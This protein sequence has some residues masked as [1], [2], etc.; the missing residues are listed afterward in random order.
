MQHRPREERTI[1]LR[2]VFHETGAHEA[3]SRWRAGGLGMKISSGSHLLSIVLVGALGCGGDD[4]PYGELES[5]PFPD[6][7]SE[8][9][10]GDA[11]S[12][13]EGAAAQQ[14]LSS[15]LAL[16]TVVD[17]PEQSLELLTGAYGGAAAMLGSSLGDQGVI[18]AAERQALIARVIRRAASGAGW[19]ADFPECVTVEETDTSVVVT[20]DCEETESGFTAALTGSIGI[21]TDGTATSF[22]VRVHAT[23]NGTVENASLSLDTAFLGDMTISPTSVD[24]ELLFQA[25]VEASSQGTSATASFLGKVV[26]GV[27]LDGP[28]CAVGG[29]IKVAVELDIDS[30]DADASFGGVGRAIFGPAC[31]QVT[32]YARASAE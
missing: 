7:A 22:S 6:L 21:E 29:D 30:P 8:T 31:N 1:G 3:R 15:A 11:Q 14:T 9:D 26:Y 12:S 18:F 2:P 27:E 4:D 25:D 23:G 32:A 20:F 10:F 17:A 24:G 16:D 13:T 19:L 28:G 5:D